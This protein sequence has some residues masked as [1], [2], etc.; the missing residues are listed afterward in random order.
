MVAINSF[1]CLHQRGSASLAAK[2]KLVPSF[3]KQNQNSTD[4][5]I[6]STNSFQ[7]QGKYCCKYCCSSPIP[8]I[9]CSNYS[10]AEFGSTE[11]SC[12]MWEVDWAQ[13]CPDALSIQDYDNCFHNID[14]Q[15]DTCTTCKGK[16]VFSLKILFIS[17]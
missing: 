1:C 7:I 15:L 10:N 3:S 8:S 13:E 4:A 11:L 14:P 12:K 5:R 9:V 2:F 6:T 16:V 17:S